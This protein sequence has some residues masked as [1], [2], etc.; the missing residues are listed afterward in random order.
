M[1]LDDLEARVRKDLEYIADRQAV[2]DDERWRWFLTLAD[3]LE[4]STACYKSAYVPAAMAAPP[5]E[6]ALRH[7]QCLTGLAASA[8]RLRATVERVAAAE[9]AAQD[10]R[11]G[12]AR[13]E[14]EREKARAAEVDA[15]LDVLCPA[16]VV[17]GAFVAGVWLASTYTGWALCA[18]GTLL[19]LAG[20]PA[21][22]RGKPRSGRPRPTP[23]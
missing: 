2:V 13:Q 19:L 7:R 22:S 20:K 11:D 21:N 3:E 1:S 10:I 14:A 4:A 16:A 12:M 15:W 18:G 6:E 8:I 17:T 5:P 9:R 23:Q